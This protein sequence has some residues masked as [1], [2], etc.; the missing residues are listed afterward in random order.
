MGRKTRVYSRIEDA[1]AIIKGLCDKQPD[2]MWCVRADT[3]IVMGIENTERSEKNLTLAKI[4]TIKGAEKA[5][6]QV[7]NIPVRYV[8]ELYWSDWNA[9]SS[10]QKQWIIF[11]ELLHCHPDFEK[12]IK[13]DCEDFKLILDKVGVDWHKSKNLPNLLTDTVKFNLE[14]RPGID[15]LS[16][17]DEGDEIMDDEEKK[18]PAP[19]KKSKKDLAED[20]KSAEAADDIGAKDE[21]DIG[22][23]GGDVIGDEDNNDNDNDK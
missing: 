18:D 17:E 19:K 2:T 7:H 22:N 15:E 8:I 23:D 12:T 5:I 4:K 13:H 1:D 16:E 3:I 6:F 21:E 9:W 20:Q 11:H 10:E 14:L